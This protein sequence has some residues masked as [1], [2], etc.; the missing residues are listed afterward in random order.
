MPQELRDD[1]GRGQSVGG[2]QRREAT[3]PAFRGGGWKGK[4][5]EIGAGLKV[6]QRGRRQTRYVKQL[7]RSLMLRRGMGGPARLGALARAK[8]CNKM[9]RDV[10]RRG[11]SAYAPPRLMNEHDAG[12][13]CEA[14]LDENAAVLCVV[15]LLEE[16]HLRV[17][18]VERLSLCI[19]SCSHIER[20]ATNGRRE[21][22]RLGPPR[23]P[24]CDC[25]CPRLL[26]AAALRLR[27][28][29]PSD[30]V[31]DAPKRLR[32]AEGG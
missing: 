13:P 21:R 4:E 11:E 18:L 23:W 32:A 2:R 6:G 22:R 27:D 8:P 7:P 17:L 19:D 15:F 30:L 28:L 20:P 1:S 26:A 29:S 12:H 31:D 5:D 10:P 16:R 24:R 9:S 3:G 25:G 14:L